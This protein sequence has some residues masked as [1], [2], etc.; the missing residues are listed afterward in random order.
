[1]IVA[2]EDYPYPCMTRAQVDWLYG[3]QYFDAKIGAIAVV[4]REQVGW[5]PQIQADL[6]V[7]V[8]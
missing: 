3:R 2:D 5:S 8:V 4:G 6:Y 1:M 7:A